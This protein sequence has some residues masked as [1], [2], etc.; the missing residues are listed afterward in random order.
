MRKPNPAVPLEAAHAAWRTDGAQS[1]RHAWQTLSCKLVTPLYGGG[2]RAGE[3]DETMPIRPSGIRGQLRF[4]WRLLYGTNGQPADVFEAETAIWGG[5]TRGGPKASKVAVRVKANEVHSSDLAAKSQLV[6]FPAY[7]LI[8]EPGG[9]PRLLCKGYGFDL[10]LRFASDLDAERRAQA[11]QA[12]RWWA[13]FG[14]VGAR[15]RRG[16]GAVK[17]EGLEPVTRAEVAE[18]G[19]RLILRTSGGDA[20]NAW[21]SAVEALQRFR[22]GQNM[23]RNPG[24]GRSRWPEADT[25]RLQTKRHALKHAPEHTVKGVYPR[26]AFGLPIVFHFKDAGDPHDQMLVPDGSDRMASP[27]ILRPYW[28]G[29][30]WQPA[31]LLVPGWERRLSVRVGFGH[32]G[33]Q[34]AWPNDDPTQARTL[35]EQIQPM[36]GRGTDPLSAFMDYFEKGRP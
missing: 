26:A 13:S 25:L 16:L 6:G 27:L 34:P 12:L 10:A 29:Q 31:A 3:I 5:I 28:N 24:P 2:V 21:T 33:Y 15:T 11:E 4:W 22:Q 7:A 14:G 23:G 18:R 17:V 9:D 30:Q 32:G 36:Q 8:I 20:A 19:G 1:D 35:A